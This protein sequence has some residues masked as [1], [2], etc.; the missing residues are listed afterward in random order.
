MGFFSKMFSKFRSDRLSVIL[1]VFEVAKEELQD[2]TEE[3]QKAI[4]EL[5]AT[6]N[7]AKKDQDRATKALAGIN[8]ILGE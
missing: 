3:N 1:G 2:Y 4:G 5:E 7:T 6:I 8:K